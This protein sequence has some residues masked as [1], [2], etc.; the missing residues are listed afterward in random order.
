MKKFPLAFLILLTAC[1]GLG[2]GDS[3][4]LD[5]EEIQYGLPPAGGKIEMEGH[6]EE[7]FFA[8]GA[9]TGLEGTPA[10]G[11]AQSHRFADGY[12]L[13]T[14]QLNVLPAEDGYF[15]EGWLVKGPS[16]ISTGQLTNNFGDARHSLRFESETDLSDHLKVI[17][18]LEPDDGNPAPAEHVAEGVLK[19]FE[20]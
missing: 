9:L 13:H 14:A 5:T 2:I 20:R 11:V 10:N 4:K 8:Y 16:I 15:Y 3:D 1:S 7:E 6:G 18:T 17:I 19:P 12:F